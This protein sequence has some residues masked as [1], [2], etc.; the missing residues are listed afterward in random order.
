VAPTGWRASPVYDNPALDVDGFTVGELE[1]EAPR[2][3]MAAAVWGT[4]EGAMFFSG[5]APLCSLDL[6]APRLAMHGTV[7][8]GPDC[9]YHQPADLWRLERGTLPMSSPTVSA[10]KGAEA[11]GYHWVRLSVNFTIANQRLTSRYWRTE[12]P[13]S[14]T[15][16]TAR[17][18]VEQKALHG[19]TRS[20]VFTALVGASTA[21]LWA[22]VAVE[23]DVSG[24]KL[25]PPAVWSRMSLDPYASWPL[26]RTSAQVR[27][28][29]A[30]P[31]PNRRPTDAQPALN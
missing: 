2:T 5:R 8:C 21:G 28:T 20:E 19:R 30:Q 6:H 29:A 1:N 14:F 24:R 9:D 13:P 16:S 7:D 25:T 22:G 17:A 15:G 12:L 11:T 18:A 3:R 23:Q 31:A 4:G 10:G 26:G 27:P